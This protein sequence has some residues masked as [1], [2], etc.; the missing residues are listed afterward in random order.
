MSG[1]FAPACS[2]EGKARPGELRR[3]NFVGHLRM[4]SYAAEREKNHEHLN[5]ARHGVARLGMLAL[6]EE[7]TSSIL[8]RLHL[9]TRFGITGRMAG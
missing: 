6:A 4:N 7:C 9:H 1:Q 8:G 5:A 3:E 2:A